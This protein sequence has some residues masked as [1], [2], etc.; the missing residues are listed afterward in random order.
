M[1]DS[2]TAP[3]TPPRMRLLAIIAAALVVALA[4]WVVRYLL[5]QQLAQAQARLNSVAELRVAQL[6]R[7][8]SQLGTFSHTVAN[9]AVL[10][11]LLQRWLT[12]GDLQARDR[13]LARLVE[14]RKAV[15]G[16]QVLVLDA[17][18]QVLAQEALAGATA[19]PEASS[20]AAPL[21]PELQQALALAMAS[22]RP[23]Y[24][25]IHRVVGAAPALR[26]DLV[27]PAARGAGSPA[28]AVVLRVDAER[29]ILPSL[30]TWPVPT[31]SG[32]SLLWRREGEQLVVQNNVRH[33]AQSAGQLRVALNNPQAAI[34][35]AL[36]GDVALN[37]VFEGFDYRGAA[38]LAEVRKVPGTDWWLT[39]KIDL[40]EVRAPVWHDAAGVLA[41]TLALLSMMAL[42]LRLWQQQQALAQARAEVAAHDQADREAHYRSAIEVLSEGVLVCD[43]QGLVISCNPAAERLVGV[44]QAQWQGRSFIAPGWQPVREDGSPMPTAEVPTARALAGETDTAPVVLGAVGPQQQKVWFEVHARPVK[45]PRDGALLAVVTSFADI[46]QR[47]DA[48]DELLRHRLHLEELVAAR[49]A[50]VQRTATSLEDAERFTR[51][52]TDA[53]P[54]RVAYWDRELRCRFANRGYLEWFGKTPA[55]VLGRTAAEIHGAAYMAPVMPRVDAAWRGVMQRFE[56]ETRLPNGVAVVHQMHYIPDLRDDGTVRGMYVMAFDITPLKRAEAAQQGLNRELSAALERAEEASR[57]KSAF[58]ANMSHEIRTP[59]N[60]IIGLTHLLARDARDSLQAERLGKV[61]NAARH[62]L[63]VI[64][65]ILDLSKI[66]SG[67]MVLEQLEFSLDALLTRC[68]ELVRDRADAKGLELVLDTDG[69]PERLLGDPTRLSQMLINLLANAVKFTEHGWVRLRGELLREDGAR[70]QV[71]FEVQDTG[72][73]I[74]P[75]R[76]ALLFG[77]FEQ[78]DNSSTRRHGGTGLGLALTRHLALLM[79]G[80][81]GLSSTPGTGSSFWFTAWLGHGRQAQPR[82]SV[83]LQGQRALVVDD[84]A[85]AGAAIV[86]RLRMIGLQAD[87]EHSGA[88][89]LERMHLEMAAA[90][91]Y[92]VLLVD[93]RMAPMDGVATLQALRQL[94]GGALPPSILVTAYDNQD[95]WQAARAAHFDAVLVKPITAS[96]LHD[97][98]LRLLDPQPLEPLLPGRQA[99]GPEAELRRQHAG[100]Q[101]LLVEDNRVNQEVA[102]ELLHA[103]GLVVETADDGERAVTL[104]TSKP[105]DLI[106]MDVQMPRLDGLEATRILRTRIGRSVP[107]VA[108]TANAFGEDRTACL[109]AGMNDHVAKP[110]DPARLYTTLLRWL[111]RPATELP[112]L[113]PSAQAGA[114]ALDWGERARRLSQVPGFEFE[115]ALEGV[116]SNRASLLRALHVFINLYGRGEPTL[117]AAD[118][119]ESRLQWRRAAHSLR[120]A[121]AAIGATQLQALLK[122]FEAAARDGAPTAELA[123]QALA[124]DTE[125]RA[126]CER[127][128]L[129]LTG[130]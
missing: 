28:V 33:Q 58:L 110:V 118:D 120:G 24:T 101:V 126:F 80:D 34:A 114:S 107:I 84:L 81:V 92:D 11:E 37:T 62:L 112:V 50:Q 63:Q 26:L 129:A 91:P 96:S 39:T 98:L 119:S 61:D 56:R 15:D 79:S 17:Q 21:S 72:P 97:T 41:I 108:M 55:E 65:D 124:I 12:E 7:W 111:P 83:L 82:E 93:W 3:P 52:I 113:A 18:G 109:A 128:E 87:V 60:A 77:A 75:E 14:F 53:L 78:A 54:G 6:E 123:A 45:S 46:T 4:G 122:A 69:L 35:S 121:S 59:M 99:D 70:L 95:M 88:A 116:A 117:A 90:R 38:V 115:R 125:L 2:T 86:E 29:S 130:A 47:K 25:G 13:L 104:A 40:S 9:S 44:S 32:E 73:G 68:F 19:T 64:N 49:T 43:A 106:L 74:A 51:T 42:A 57:A 127:L 76:Q 23:A 36:R 100:Q 85:E 67:K 94:L 8:M 71:R 105:Y 31:E 16:E 27:V 5:Q 22:G 102:E 10:A 30:Q 48:A 66:E 1:P 103:V 89:A 20:P